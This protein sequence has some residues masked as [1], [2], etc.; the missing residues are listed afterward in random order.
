[1]GPTCESSRSSVSWCRS[2]LVHFVKHQCP[3]QNNSR[4]QQAFAADRAKSCALSAAAAET[5]IVQALFQRRQIAARTPAAI[6]S[7]G[8]NTVVQIEVAG[9]IAISNRTTRP[10]LANL[11]TGVRF[12]EPVLTRSTKARKPDRLMGS[13]WVKNQVGKQIEKVLLVDDD[14]VMIRPVVARDL[15]RLFD[16]IVSRSDR[17]RC[18]K[19]SNRLCHQTGHRATCGRINSAGKE[20]TPGTSLIRLPIEFGQQCKTSPANSFPHLTRIVWGLSAIASQ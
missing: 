7:A 5:P 6:S 16:L 13:S 18:V 11:T 12:R 2:P 20:T 19:C 4:R 14:L 8:S 17:Y 15:S 9:I 10:S 1:M 3:L